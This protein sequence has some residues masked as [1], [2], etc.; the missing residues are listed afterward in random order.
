M[1]VEVGERGAR[2]SSCGTSTA[3]LCGCPASAGVATS[4]SSST[5]WRS[6][7]CAA[8]SCAPCATTSPR[9]TGTTWSYSRSRWTPRSR[10][11]PG[12]TQEHFQ[13]GLLSD[14]W[15][16]GDVARLYG[17]FDSE[18]GLAIRGTF[19]I[20][21]DGVVR[22]KVVNPIPQARDH[23]RIL[24]GARRARLGVSV[25]GRPG[26]YAVLPLRR[27]ADGP[28]AG[29]ERPGAVAC[30]ATSWSWSAPAARNLASGP[31][32]SSPAPGAPACT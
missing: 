24:E 28:G 1:A 23:R 7:A 29:E 16:H 4:C 17:V 26:G 21:K 9:S 12:L 3:R 2:T 32:S 13:F 10:T 8:V 22:W 6:A 11:A 18:R 19:V 14:F 15:P 27:A 30:C 31:P 25:R 20:D 5:R